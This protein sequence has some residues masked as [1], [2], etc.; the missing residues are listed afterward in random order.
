MEIVIKDKCGTGFSDNCKKINEKKENIFNHY[1]ANVDRCNSFIQE[2]GDYERNWGD[3]YRIKEQLFENTDDILAIST[4]QINTKFNK[5][6]GQFIHENKSIK[7]LDRDRIIIQGNL[8]DPQVLPGFIICEDNPDR[9]GS[10]IISYYKVKKTVNY[11][12]DVIPSDVVI[13]D[14]TPN[15][16][17]ESVSVESD[18]LPRSKKVIAHSADPPRL[19]TYINIANITLPDVENKKIYKNHG[20]QIKFTRNGKLEIFMA[21]NVKGLDG[22]DATMGNNNYDSDSLNPTDD[23]D[24]E[25]NDEQRTLIDNIVSPNAD[26]IDA[27]PIKPYNCSVIL[28]NKSIKIT[29]R[30][31]CSTRAH[32]FQRYGIVTKQIF[33]VISTQFFGKGNLSPSILLKIVYSYYDYTTNRVVI[34][35]TINKVF[36]YEPYDSVEDA[37]PYDFSAGEKNRF[38]NTMKFFTAKEGFL[39]CW[40]YE[41]LIKKGICNCYMGVEDLF[42]SSNLPIT[43]YDANKMYLNNRDK[44]KWFDYYIENKKLNILSDVPSGRARFGIV[45]M[46]EVDETVRN[47]KDRHMST[48]ENLFEILYAKICMGF[49]SNAHLYDDHDDNIMVK[50]VDYVRKYVIT[51][52]KRTFTFYMKDSKQIK[53]IDLERVYRVQNRNILINWNIGGGVRDLFCSTYLRLLIH[54]INGRYIQ[55][56]ANAFKD[57]ITGNVANRLHN[58]FNEFKRIAPK[59]FLTPPPEGTKVVEMVANFDIP[60]DVPEAEGGVRNNFLFNTDVPPANRVKRYHQRYGGVK[61]D[62][63]MRKFN[64]GSNVPPQA[65]GFKMV[66]RI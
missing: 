44:K 40:A 51:C 26:I 29:I 32:N 7:E 39:G 43:N 27:M 3:G 45:E 10:Y 35:N 4:T 64:I 6:D 8:N 41:N 13:E 38:Y 22:A 11:I 34:I 19:D 63:L 24:L 28:D 21:E 46:E 49:F 37:R 60:L 65:G 9:E 14:Y 56:I 61:I 53:Y 31:R 59:S 18:E 25:L 16:Y 58:F 33:N 5:L 54:G 20:I 48:L 42:F 55:T 12:R 52:N 1:E 47:I 66:P 36:Y 15:Y 62:T 50:V 23:A 2:V 30:R 17:V 57:K